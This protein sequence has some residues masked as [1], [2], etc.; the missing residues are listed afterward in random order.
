MLR[1]K[2]NFSEGPPDE[3]LARRE[4]FISRPLQL[5]A[6]LSGRVS[7]QRADDDSRT[8]YFQGKF[9]SHYPSSRLVNTLLAQ[10]DESSAFEIVV[11][12][13]T[14]RSSSSQTY[15]HLSQ[16]ISLSLSAPMNI[17]VAALGKRGGMAKV[18]EIISHLVS[19]IINASV[20][21]T[22]L[23]D[24]LMVAHLVA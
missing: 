12:D 15:W 22:D 2:R 10:E 23:T 5:D 14:P 24:I 16:A 1:I 20:K 11:A 3:V 21:K 7:L 19:N 18:N 9:P 13:Q 17:R 6:V 8:I 4:S